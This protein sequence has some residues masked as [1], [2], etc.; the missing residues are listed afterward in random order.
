[1]S[2]EPTATDANATEKFYL[3]SISLPPQFDR[4]EGVVADL[5]DFHGVVLI[6]EEN[7]PSRTRQRPK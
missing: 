3:P 1:M 5:F 4:I 2:H 7:R 6:P